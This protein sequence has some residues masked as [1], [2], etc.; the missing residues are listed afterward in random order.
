MK[1]AETQRTSLCNYLTIT[2]RSCLSPNFMCKGTPKTRNAEVF[3]WREGQGIIKPE[4]YHLQLKNG[5]GYLQIYHRWAKV[6]GSEILQNNPLSKEPNIFWNGEER[7]M[8]FKAVISKYFDKSC[9]TT[10]VC[11]TDCLQLFM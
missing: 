8:G 7:K 5:R 6:L 3:W 1:T 2:L 10:A 9:K 11:R 4:I